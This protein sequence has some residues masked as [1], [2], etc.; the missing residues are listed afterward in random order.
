[1]VSMPN[2]TSRGVR[3][4]ALTIGALAVIGG[5]WLPACG[6]KTETS[7]APPTGARPTAATSAQQAAVSPPQGA[8]PDSPVTNAAE[9]ERTAAGT[10]IGV[11]GTVVARAPTTAGAQRTLKVGATVYKDDTIETAKNASI[12]IVLSHNNAQWSLS[13]G[14][15]KRVDRSVAWRAP[16][17]TRVTAAGLLARQA[18]GKTVAA[19]RHSESEAAESAETATRK[20]VIS[21]SERSKHAPPKTKRLNPRERKPQTKPSTTS[22]PPRPSTPKA[23][24]RPTREVRERKTAPTNR[25]IAKGAPGLRNIFGGDVAGVGAGSPK[26][27]SPVGTATPRVGKAGRLRGTVSIRSVV[28][29]GTTNTQLMSIK[30]NVKRR[31][32]QFVFCYEKALRENPGISGILVMELEIDAAGRVVSAKALKDSVGRATA[33][34]VASKSKRMR[35]AKPE[36]GEMFA[37]TVTLYFKKK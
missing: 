13:S 10:V 23:E 19:G 37:I 6:K 33:L 34:C 36:D 14:R 12:N 2:A 1:M 3:C 21:P 22:A 24:S 26:V 4:R 28:A 8:T 25:K 7:S 5:L 18:R 16:K 35:F 32:R 11:T 20:Q 29:A 30:K 31:V 9:I 17:V 15:R 27:K